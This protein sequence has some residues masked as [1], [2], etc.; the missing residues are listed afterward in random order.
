MALQEDISLTWNGGRFP[1]DTP[2]LTVLAGLRGSLDAALVFDVDTTTEIALSDVTDS[3][4]K[5]TWTS[6]A[7]SETAKTEEYDLQWQL[8]GSETWNSLPDPL[9]VPKVRFDHLPAD[10]HIFFRVRKRA[11]SSA[12][13]SNFSRV[14][15]FKTL[16][17][18][19][20]DSAPSDHRK[21]NGAGHAH[22]VRSQTTETS[23]QSL[24]LP[25]NLSLR[26]AQFRPSP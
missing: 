14:A 10:T 21:S 8:D 24:F 22:K 19:R 23:L 18:P 1:R 2:T 16:A 7:S 26:P 3:S 17:A 20:Q 9:A 12:T 6:S 4:I 5:V 11:P 15:A 13:W 25:P